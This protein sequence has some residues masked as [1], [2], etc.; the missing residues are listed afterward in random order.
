AGGRS[1][2]RSPSRVG[3]Q[4]STSEEET[5]EMREAAEEASIVEAVD[6]LP[7]QRWTSPGGHRLSASARERL[8][9]LAGV[10]RQVR[11][12]M[13]LSVPE[14]TT[15]TEHA[16]GLDI[17]VVAAVPGT[18]AHARRHLD[19]FTAAAAD[20]TAGALDAPTLG[21]FLAYLDVAEE[22]ERGLE[23]VAAEPDPDAVQILTV[24]AAKGLEWDWV[25]VAGL[26][27]GDFPS[28]THVPAADKPVTASGW[29]TSIGT[30]PYPLRGA[31]DALPALAVEEAT[32]HRD[33]AQ[34]RTEFRIDEGAR[35]LQEERR[36]A[37]VAMTRARHQLLLTG[38]FWADQ[39]TARRLSPFLTELATVPHVDLG[40]MPDHALPEG[41]QYESNPNRDEQERRTWPEPALV[42][43]QQWQEL[44]SAA[45]ARAGE[46]AQAGEYPQA[47]ERAQAG[48]Y[49]Q[50]GEY[51]QAGERA[52][53]GEPARA[54]GPV[55]AA[56]NAEEMAGVSD[57][58]QAWWR[59]A[60]LL[61]A[62]RDRARDSRLGRP[63]HLS[64]SAVV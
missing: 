58:A 7:P 35:H 9:H 18:V 15:A 57:H 52:R 19:A 63:G 36:L 25:A 54:G 34:A 13:H 41:S 45:R 56:H 12:V 20:Y 2:S 43:G 51:P 22:Q 4:E 21:G 39:A 23:V 46:R 37:Y 61:L 55:G 53:S 60:E 29:L 50:S 44:W 16:L 3:E 62:E 10:I 28:I 33:M 64:A 32:P 14:V 30:L 40:S 6:R 38:S 49:P 24:H 27:M 59:D 1:V 26:M 8:T 31:A 48:E 5:Q 11:S 47:G 17:E 42:I